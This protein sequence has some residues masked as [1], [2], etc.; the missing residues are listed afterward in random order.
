MDAI[1][2]FLQKSA[3]VLPDSRLIDPKGTIMADWP[4]TDQFGNPKII[5]IELEPFFCFHCGKPGGY[6]PRE[7]MSFV[8]WMCPKCAESKSVEACACM[9]SDEQFWQVVGAEMM[10]RFGHILTQNELDALAE[11]GKLGSA[12]EKLDRESPYKIWHG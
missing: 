5:R 7:I 1:E 9:S 12:L 6:T 8:S 2:S 3:P 4:I 10:A 11:Q